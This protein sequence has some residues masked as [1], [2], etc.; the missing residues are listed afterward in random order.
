MGARFLA[1]HALRAD[2]GVAGTHDRLAV[3]DVRHPDV[4]EDSLRQLLDEATPIVVTCVPDDF[5]DVRTIV[6]HAQT[7]MPTLRVCVEPIAGPSLSLGVI[8]SLAD[9]LGTD[10]EESVAWQISALDY[11][12]AQQWA[13]AWMPSVNKLRS[14]QPSVGQHARSWGPGSGFLAIYGDEP[15]VVSASKAPLK[16]IQPRPGSTLIHSPCDGPGWV[17]TAVNDALAA[18]DSTEVLSLRD[19]IDAFGTTS[20][21][22]FL[23]LPTD[24]HQKS[25]PSDDDITVCGGCGMLHARQTCPLCKMTYSSAS[26][27]PQGAMP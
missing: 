22:E 7:R 16:H 3:A 2:L 12:R 24:Y 9:E 18:A 1:V 4:V 5:D 23:A 27:S 8:S 21:M 13:A 25:Q 6:T 20:A 17:L 19:P 15:R 11:M 10:S 14:P 26:M